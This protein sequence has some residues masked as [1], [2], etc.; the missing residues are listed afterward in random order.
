MKKFLIYAQ[1]AFFSA[2]TLLNIYALSATNVEHHEWHVV[3]AVFVA[4]GQF[5]FPLFM[6]CMFTAL[7]CELIEEKDDDK[8]VSETRSVLSQESTNQETE[9]D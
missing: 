5:I 7:I 6:F 1:L 4:I 2:I 9:T 8:T 3:F